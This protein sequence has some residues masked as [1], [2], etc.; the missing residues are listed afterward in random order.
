[1]RTRPL[2]VA[3]GLPRGLLLFAV[4]SACSNA[5]APPKKAAVP[6]PVDPATAGRIQ[7]TVRYE[8]P[9][10]AREPINMRS[11]PQCA[12]QHAEPV[13]DETVVVQDGHV[14][15]AV[16]W[17]KGGLE[18]WVF[19]TPTEPVVFD[20]KGC[21]YHPHVAAAL[22]SQPVQ[23]VNSDP[24]PH[25]VHGRPEVVPAWNFM[26]SRQGSSRTLT[27]EK[28]E[29]AIPIGC[30][31]H[32]WMRAYLVVVDN[33]YVAVTPAS[34]SVT[35]SNV[36]PGAYVVAV[37]HEKLGVKEQHITLAASAAATADFSFSGTK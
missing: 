6:T 30:D 33:P 12:A 5:P 21:V 1:M 36:P 26:M 19:A 31:I 27:F 14:A 2:S 7:V 15:N 34:G 3:G 9:P 18:G 37:W 22:L 8:G 10:P 11:A 24:E 29:V 16:V 23:F 13:S 35:L 32:P 17:I 4:L 20:Q 25:N 28:P